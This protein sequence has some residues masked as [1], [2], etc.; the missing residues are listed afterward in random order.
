MK[1]AASFTRSAA[2]F[3]RSAR[4]ARFSRRCSPFRASNALPSS[5]WS[6]TSGQ[7]DSRWPGT[8]MSGRAAQS[9]GWACSSRR[10]KLRG[11]IDRATLMDGSRSLKII[12]IGFNTDGTG[13]TRVMHAI[14]RR[15]AGRHE[16]HYLGIG[17]SGDT[18]VDRGLTIHPTNP[19]GGDVFAAFQAKRMIEESAPDLVFILHDI[20]CFE[21]YL[22]TLGPYRDRLRIV[23]YIPLDG[24]IVNAKDAAALQRADRVV[25]Y[26]G[27]AQRQFEAAFERLTSERSGAFPAVD[28][29]PHG[30]DRDRFRPCPALL[31]GSLA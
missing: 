1:S 13:L 27:F 9:R 31:H 17:Y 29:I 26:T 28:V 12:C 14:M 7:P 2:R 23:A 5:C 11:M 20:W 10:A 8:G 22:N 25:V 6:T 3:T 4:T 19:K 24:D 21:H 15:L 30:V 18:V 16:I